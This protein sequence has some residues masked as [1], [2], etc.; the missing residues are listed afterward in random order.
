[1]IALHMQAK[2]MKSALERIKDAPMSQ[3][4]ME[5]LAEETIRFIEN[6]PHHNPEFAPKSECIKYWKEYYESRSVIAR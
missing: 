2:I 5:E 6:Y 3:V 1:M 4:E